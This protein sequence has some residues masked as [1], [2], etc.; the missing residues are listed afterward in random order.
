MMTTRPGSR[1]FLAATLT[2]ASLLAAC[3]DGTPSSPVI[4]DIEP[5]AGARAEFTV[6]PLDLDSVALLTPLGNLGPP[7]HVLPTD[8]AYFYQVDFDARP[9][10][11]STR[12]L[13]VRAPATGIVHFVIHQPSHD[14]KI[15]FV[16]T[17]DFGYYLDHVLLNQGIEPGDTVMAG[18]V[19][20]VTNPGGSLD[21][22]A[23]DFRVTLSGLVNPNR[24]NVTSRHTVSPWKYVVEP[25]RSAAYAKVRRHPDIADKDGK[26]DFGVPGKLVGDWYEQGAPTDHLAGGP[27]GWPRTVAFVYDYYDPRLVRISIGGT[28]APPGV[29]TIPDDQP[30]PSTISVSSGRVVYRLLY[31]GSRTQYGLMVA[32]LL[33]SETLRLEVFVGESLVTADFTPGAYTYKR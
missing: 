12:V 5:L 4:G 28:V 21:L 19:I 2:A 14:Q 20:G 6:M 27:A 10:V 9:W 33:D 8:H 29:W 13:P 15:Q 7:G 18:E 1:A 32:Q 31:T 26:I 16:V 3:G 22:G 17:K 23:Y 24:Y 25:L 11:P 30:D